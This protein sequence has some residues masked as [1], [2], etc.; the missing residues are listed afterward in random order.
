MNNILA[1]RAALALAAAPLARPAVA[2]G[3]WPTRP[4][5]LVVPFPPGG[6]NDVVARPL[7]DRMQALLGQ[8]VVI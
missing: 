1:R 4:I 3:T 8:P 2:Q 7:A 5:R 6:S